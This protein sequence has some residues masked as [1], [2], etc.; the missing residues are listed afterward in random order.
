MSDSRPDIP[1]PGSFGQEE[2]VAKLVRLAREGPEVPADGAAKIKAAI[3]PLWQAEVRRR[4]RRRVVLWSGAGLA[5]A[6][7]LLLAVTVLFTRPAPIVATVVRV[8]GSLEAIDKHGASDLITGDPAARELIAGTMLTTTKNQRAALELGEGVSL[9]IDEG[10][11]VRLVSPERL[12]LERGAVYVDSQASGRIEVL[13]PMALVREIGTQFEVRHHADELIV[14]VR[15]GEV[16]V[17]GG[18]LDVGITRGRSMTLDR[19]GARSIQTVD[20]WA[21]RWAWVQDIGPSFDI[22]GETAAAFLRWVALETG[23]TIRFAD[24]EAKQ[25]VESV[26]L[27]GSIAGAGAGAAESLDIVLP[28]CDLVGLR[29]GQNELLITR[30]GS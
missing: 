10:T 21:E 3:R 28:G 13:T 9:R 16:L 29:Q 30:P 2:M 1:T 27:H 11:R 23:W 8:I 12:E 20:P 6:A 19:N 4:F 22:E 26:V 25:L 24:E 5:A 7:S 18:D 17:T 14:T 15:D